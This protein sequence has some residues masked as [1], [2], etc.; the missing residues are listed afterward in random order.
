MQ[1]VQSHSTVVMLCGAK[2]VPLWAC[3]AHIQQVVAVTLLA[4]GPIEAASNTETSVMQ[5]VQAAIIAA[6]AQQARDAACE[7]AHGSR[8]SSGSSGGSTDTAAAASESAQPSNSS[9][10]SKDCSMLYD[11]TERL[12]SSLGKM[13]MTVQQLNDMGHG[14]QI[15]LMAGGWV[16]LQQ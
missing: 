14:L 10:S 7:H 8:G 5:A 13:V 15:M 16:Q 2:E 12:A 6:A 9:S 11:R 4:A 3:L 1:S